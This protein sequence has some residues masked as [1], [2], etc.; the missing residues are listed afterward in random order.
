[1][2][3]K[4]AASTSTGKSDKKTSADKSDK[5]GKAKTTDA[6]EENQ[7]KVSSFASQSSSWLA[8][9]IDYIS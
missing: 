2:V 8:L 7:T 9:C 3:K 4:G 5:K 6:G 1:M